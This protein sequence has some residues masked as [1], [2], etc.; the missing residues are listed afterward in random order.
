MSWRHYVAIGDSLTTG[1]GDPI[2]G[3][4]GSSWA[5]RL[6]AALRPLHPDFRYTNLARRGLRADEVRATQLAPA[7]ALR[8]D[9]VSLLAGGNDLFGPEWDA[10]RYRDEMAAM[11]GAL[12]A[13]GAT[14]ITL[15][16]L[17]PSAVLPPRLARRLHPRLEEAHDLVRDLSRRH[18]CVCV[19]AWSLPAARDPRIWS[20]DRKHPNAL[21]SL[22]VAA[23]AARCLQ[24]RAG[25][26]I[27]GPS[28]P[29]P[30]TA[31]LN[32]RSADVSRDHLPEPL[33]DR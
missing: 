2:G 17:D 25:V 10:R 20:A 9:L 19:D 15:T 23:E 12:A 28:L 5:D 27:A 3:L 26:P 31:L 24:G 29:A 4:E 32:G 8:P 30:V 11:L 33:P 1:G 22:L 18:G 6:A 7:L 21:G 16:M 14:V 13:S